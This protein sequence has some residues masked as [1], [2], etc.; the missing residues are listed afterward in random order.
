VFK[1][2]NVDEFEA[3]LRKLVKDERDI[4]LGTGHPQGGNRISK[5]RGKDGRSGGVVDPS[6]KVYGTDNLYVCDAS[7]FPG[8][9]T[10]NPQLTVMTMAH[11]AAGLIQ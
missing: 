3:D 11:Y 2:E 8:A 6:F 5:M 9:T 1:A 7:V 4:L 10:V